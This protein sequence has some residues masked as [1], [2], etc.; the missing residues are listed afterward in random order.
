M[1]L[2]RNFELRERRQYAT[3]SPAICSSAPRRHIQRTEPPLRSEFVGRP[4]ATLEKRSPINR[5]KSTEG[6]DQIDTK[7]TVQ[8]KNR[9]SIK[10]L[11]DE[12]QQHFATGIATP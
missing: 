9:N 11:H 3:M 7:V 12:M 6:V 10:M 1:E 2:S 8:M 5:F 4:P